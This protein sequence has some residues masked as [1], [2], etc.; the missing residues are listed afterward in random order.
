MSHTLLWRTDWRHGTE[1]DSKEEDL[2]AAIIAVWEQ[3][4]GS[5]N[6][7]EEEQSQWGRGERQ[8]CKQDLNKIYFVLLILYF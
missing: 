4:D 5:F 1:Q 2:Q 8:G 7:S 6:W 3:D